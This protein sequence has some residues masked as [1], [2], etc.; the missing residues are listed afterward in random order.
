M[1]FGT[2]FLPPEARLQPNFD[3]FYYNLVEDEIRSKIILPT[4]EEMKQSK[5]LSRLY[6]TGTD[7]ENVLNRMK[8]KSKKKKKRKCFSTSGNLVQDTLSKIMETNEDSDEEDTIAVSFTQP[9]PLEESLTVSS[10]SYSEAT[11][12]MESQKAPPPLLSITETISASVKSPEQYSISASLM[13]STASLASGSNA[14]YHPYQDI[15]GIKEKH[16]AKPH[17]LS[18]TETVVHS[19][20]QIGGKFHIENTIEP[21]EEKIQVK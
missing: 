11:A 2:V 17:L 5:D 6:A 8:P 13:R 21:Y 7:S 19:D 1:S 18:V 3:K 16:M 14:Q 10:K 9:V 4:E 12:I 15:R 20:R